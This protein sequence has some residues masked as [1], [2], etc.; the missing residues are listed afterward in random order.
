MKELNFEA[1][2]S[3]IKVSLID[4]WQGPKYSLCL[5]PFLQ[6]HRKHEKNK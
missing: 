6:P 5:I 2:S 1:K 3:D 4:V